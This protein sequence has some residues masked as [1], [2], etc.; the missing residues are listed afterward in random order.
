MGA[1]T[2]RARVTAR[3]LFPAAN[4]HSDPGAQNNPFARG[5]G[6]HIDCMIAVQLV[7]SARVILELPGNKVMLH[8]TGPTTPEQGPADVNAPPRAGTP[9]DQ[10]GRYKR[11]RTAMRFAGALITL[12]PR[13]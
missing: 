2:R 11:S 5:L 6:H 7:G 10:T 8:P 9:A 12:P 3:N 13:P 1:R 4:S